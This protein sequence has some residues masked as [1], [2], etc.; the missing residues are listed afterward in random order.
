MFAPFRFQPAL[1]R[2]LFAAATL[3]LAFSGFNAHAQKTTAFPHSSPEA[4]GVSAAGIDSFLTAVGNS[5]HE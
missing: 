3:L 5:K 2:H 1:R 4:E